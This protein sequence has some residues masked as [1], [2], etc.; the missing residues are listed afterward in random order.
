MVDTIDTQLFCQNDTPDPALIFVSGGYDIFVDLAQQSYQLAIDE[1]NALNGFTVTPLSFNVD[2]N[3][4]GQL[5]QFQRPQR[6]VLDLQ[7]LE[8]QDPGTLAD[9]PAFVPEIPDLVSAPTFDVEAPELAF[10]A[11]PA[12]PTVPVPVAPAD[13]GVP[14]MPVSPDYVLPDVPTFEELN[15][16]SA[17]TITLPTFQGDRPTLGDLSL[18]GDWNFSPEAYASEVLPELQAKI[19]EW[20]QGGTGLPPAIEQALFDRA[21]G[22]LEEGSVRDLQT[23]AE[24]HSSKGFSQP[25]GILDGRV[26]E[27]IIANKKARNEQGRDLTILYHQ[28]ELVNIRGAVEKGIA[29]EQVTVNLHIQEQE[30]IF[31]AASFLR[32]SEIAVIN[33]KVQGFNA[34]V[35]AYQADA[36]VFETQIRAAL[37]A[38]EVYKAQLEGERVK[39]ELN[40][41]KAQIYESQIRGLNALAELY[42]TRIEAVKTEVEANRQVILTYQAKVEAY[43]KRWDAFR[44]ELDAYRADIDGQK[45]RGEIFE[46]QTRAY[47]TRITAWDREQQTLF[48]RER[49]R[50]T[51][52]DQELRVWDGG[53]RLL[54]ANLEKE[55][56]RISAVAQSIDAQARMYQADAAVETAASAAVD[57]TFELGL[58]KEEARTNVALKQAEININQAIQLQSLLLRSKETRAQVLGQLSASTMSA[59]N[60]SAGVSSSRSKGES[61]ST[62]VSWSGEAEDLE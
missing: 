40:V 59:I 8:F 30:L 51:Q 29:L 38:V 3:F 20:L 14:S 25:N 44:S 50:T 42:R 26:T 41:Q 13:P 32:E 34:Q 37:A 16:P 46:S 7:G 33:V 19:R 52:H 62:S 28:E 48:D 47:A 61:C 53:L 12:T 57:R 24:I 1:T 23:A 45:A 5:A 21:T 2:F 6:P 55:G 27:I 15:I 9:P 43:G 35:Q 39:G 31:K 10:G 60:F 4:S 22:R 58:R 11:R 49:L 36:Q 56:R 54:A 18:T 17:P